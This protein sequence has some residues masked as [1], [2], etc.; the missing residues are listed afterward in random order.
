[1]TI[2]ANSLL[3]FRKI[4]VNGVSDNVS[5]IFFDRQKFLLGFVG[6]NQGLSELWQPSL[7]NY[8]TDSIYV[9]IPELMRTGIP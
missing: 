5:P 9:E 4:G 8:C 1:M 2:D 3:A 7:V 6:G